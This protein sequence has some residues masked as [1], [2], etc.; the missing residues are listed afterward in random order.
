MIASQNTLL[1]SRPS[2][3]F[4][5]I[6]LTSRTHGEHGTNHDQQDHG[7]HT[8]DV[9]HGAAQI[10]AGDLGDGSAVVALG[11]HAREIVVDSAGED[12]AEGDPQEDHRSPH[13]AADG[14]EDGAQ[15]GNVQQLHQEQ[16]PLGHNDV[17]NTVV[18]GH[19]G[20]FPVVRTEDPVDDLAV[21][22]VA[23]DED[24]KA[25]EKANHTFPSL[26]FRGRS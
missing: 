21:K 13:G 15:A 18:D 2:V 23:A 16:L 26:I 24:Q 22:Q 9:L 17:V 5:P 20:S 12:S 7:E 8:H 19:S 25:N 11:Q 6:S 3:T 10:N 4:V 14:S 1:T